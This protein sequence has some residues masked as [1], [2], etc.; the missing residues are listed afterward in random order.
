MAKFILSAYNLGTVEPNDQKRRPN[1]ARQRALRI[2]VMSSIANDY[3]GFEMVSNET[4]K[5][6]EESGIEFGRAEILE[7]L[8]ELIRNDYAKAYLLS[9]HPPHVVVAAYSEACADALWFMLTTAG[10]RAM[11]E[12]EAGTRVRRRKTASRR[13]RDGVNYF[14]LY[15]IREPR[16]ESHFAKVYSGRR[17]ANVVLSSITAYGLFHK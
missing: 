2:Y 11:K 13:I 6:A 9:P 10:I 1:E 14:S 5:W 17:N 3:E 4:N 15:A 16:K 8:S 7:E 12:L